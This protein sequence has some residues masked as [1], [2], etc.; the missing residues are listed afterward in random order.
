MKTIYY[1]LVNVE[2][3]H[4]KSWYKKELSMTC[5]TTS[6]IELT[7]YP[8]SMDFIRKKLPASKKGI[9]FRVRKIE[10]I[11]ELGKSFHYE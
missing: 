2:Y 1:A 8:H 7:K 6:I 3:E 11:K 9:R 10:C 5:L 4:R